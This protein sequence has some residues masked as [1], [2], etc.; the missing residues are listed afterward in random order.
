VPGSWTQRPPDQEPARLAEE[1][2]N[3]RA[4]REMIDLEELED[5]VCLLF[6]LRGHL[7][8]E[9]PDALRRNPESTTSRPDIPRVKGVLE[10]AGDDAEVGAEIK[11][12]PPVLPAEPE[13]DI[14]SRSRRGSTPG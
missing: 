7:M 10:I 9:E 2:L 14:R 13:D 12:S 4:V 6:H 3:H 5:L 8:V 1:I 11:A